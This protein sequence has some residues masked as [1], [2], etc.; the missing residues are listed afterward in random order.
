MRSDQ[1]KQGIEK[2]PHRTLF[3]ALGMLD[4]EMQRPLEA[5]E[6]FVS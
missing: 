2:A 3:K 6:Q 5:Y 1:M 4:E